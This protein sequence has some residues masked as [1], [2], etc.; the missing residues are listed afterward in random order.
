MCWQTIRRPGRFPERLPLSHS[1]SLQLVQRG[2][3]DDPL[4][5]GYPQG[6]LGAFRISL[7]SNLST[8]YHK[9]RGFGITSQRWIGTILSQR[10]FW[11]G[12]GAKPR[13]EER[14]SIS[15]TLAA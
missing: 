10:R 14:R 5:G 11:E 13:S 7:S 6:A 4:G 9:T 3:P 2:L 8:I 15:V 12:M 1:R